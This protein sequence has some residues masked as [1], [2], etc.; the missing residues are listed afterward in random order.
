METE[1]RVVLTFTELDG[2]WP[3]TLLCVALA[4]GV[5]LVIWQYSRERG[6]L[7][8]WAR[9][10]LAA[11]RCVVWLVITGTLSGP[12]LAPVETRRLPPE[13]VVL[14]DSSQSMAIRDA[15]EGEAASR[16]ANCMPS[17]NPLPR[18]K[19]CWPAPAGFYLPAARFR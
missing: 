2:P 5:A 9:R 17:S 7:G 19:L 18:P 14:R 16:L 15:Y 11:L 4:A 10:G 3:T 8:K 12:A 13:I 6:A 1:T